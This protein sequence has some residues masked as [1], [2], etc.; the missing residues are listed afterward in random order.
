MKK[1]D[2]TWIL[3][4][5][6]DLSK[7]YQL[8]KREHAVCGE[9]EGKPETRKG[10]LWGQA[11]SLQV[12]GGSQANQGH[13]A[14]KHFKAVHGF[15]AAVLGMWAGTQCCLPAMP[16]LCSCLPAPWGKGIAVY[17]SAGVR[18]DSHWECWRAGMMANMVLMGNHHKEDSSMREADYS[19]EYQRGKALLQ[20]HKD[21]LWMGLRWIFKLPSTH[22]CH[23]DGR[24]G[25]TM[26]FVYSPASVICF[27]Q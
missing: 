8:A 24:H 23:T 14:Y 27:I 10:C 21:S 16:Y 12:R 25:N 20:T 15:T 3:S 2:E 4:V 17:H 1:G 9:A 19:H 7:C 5:V 13:C 18:R 22:K 11:N 6:L 26:F